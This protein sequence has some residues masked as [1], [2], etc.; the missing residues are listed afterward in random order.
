MPGVDGWRFCRPPR[1]AEYE[2]FNHIPILVVSDAF[3]GDDA[4]RITA[5]LGANAFRDQ[6]DCVRVMMTADPDPELALAWTRRGA[7]AQT[8]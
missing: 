3:S 1:S 5:D 4:A 8:F 2:A 7:V 6:P